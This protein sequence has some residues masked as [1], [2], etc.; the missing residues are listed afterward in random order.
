[1]PGGTTVRRWRRGP[2]LDLPLDTLP[3]ERPEGRPHP[4]GT[5]R[6]PVHYR[7]PAEEPGARRVLAL[8]EASW[9]QQLQLGFRAPPSDEGAIGP[10]PRLDAYLFR[11]VEEC[12]CDALGGLDG[13][14][15]DDQRPFLVIDPWGEYG[16]D[17][18]AATVAH[19]L[20]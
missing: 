2:P 18:L 7:A 13:T 1:F 9:D 19:E 6:V 5:A 8:L 3:P 12:Y 10:D 4:A 15:W 17:E 11:G 20:N 16:G 14:P